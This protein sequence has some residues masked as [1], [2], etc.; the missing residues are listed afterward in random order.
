MAAPFS[1]GLART[2][3]RHN[4]LPVKGDRGGVGRL[5]QSPTGD[6]GREVEA[7]LKRLP[8]RLGLVHVLTSVE[9]FCRAIGKASV[10]SNVLL[11]LRKAVE[12]DPQLKRL[13]HRRVEPFDRLEGD[14]G[15]DFARRQLG[16]GEDIALAVLGLGGDRP[17]RDR[18]LLP[19]SSPVVHH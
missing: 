12:G 16:E 14:R 10:Q 11:L 8:N 13:W 6:C 19:P 17:A 9:L 5:A 15:S 1:R 4:L 7:N 3:A 18:A 2:L